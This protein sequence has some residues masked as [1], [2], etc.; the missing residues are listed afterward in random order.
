[1]AT[2]VIMWIKWFSSLAMGDVPD[3]RLDVSIAMRPITVLSPVR[4]T[5]PRQVPST[6]LVEKKAR[7][8]VSSGLSCVF[9]GDLD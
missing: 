4:I 3:P 5:I 6:A 7:F 9:S 1:M 2:P 8:L